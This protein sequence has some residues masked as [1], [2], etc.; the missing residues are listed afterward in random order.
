MEFPGD[1][2]GRTAPAQKQRER[3]LIREEQHWPRIGMDHR[4]G[5]HGLSS[6]RPKPIQT[7]MENN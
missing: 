2:Y 5:G 1:E 4:V 3:D 7:Q 6:D